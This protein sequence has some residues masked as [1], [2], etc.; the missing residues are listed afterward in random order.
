LQTVNDLLKKHKLVENMLENQPM[1]RRKLVTSLVQKQHMVELHTLLKRLSAP[2]VGSILTALSLEDAQLVWE[3]I[4]DSGATSA[5]CAG[6][7]SRNLGFLH[8][9]GSSSFGFTAIA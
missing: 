7:K 9:F 4:S 5:L 2:E 3:Q 6:S 1:K 8:S